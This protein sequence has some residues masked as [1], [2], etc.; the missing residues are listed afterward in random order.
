MENFDYLF[1]IVTISIFISLFLAVF[2]VT[3][4]S[5]NKLSNRL[6]ALFLVLTTIDVSGFL[7]QPA[8]GEMSNLAMFRNLVIFLQLPTLYLY[9]LSASYTNFILKW[10]HLL[11]VLSFVLVN[12]VFV[13]RFYLANTSEKISFLSDF[14]NVFEVQFNHVFLHVQVAF[15]IVLI[16]LALRKAKKLYLQNYTGN[17][18]QSHQWLFQL[19]V[20]ITIFYVLALVKNIFKFSTNDDVSDQI[21]IGLYVLN[22]VIICWYLFKALHHPTLFKSVN[23]NLKLV[24]TIISE[25]KKKSTATVDNITSNA[26]L[27]KLQAYMKTEKPFLNASLTIQD[28]S[29][30]IDIPVRELSVLI[31]HTLEQHFFDFVN[32]YRIKKAQELLIDTTDTKR[33]VLEILYEVGFNSKSSFNTAFKKHTGVTPTAYRKNNS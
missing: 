10:K 15:Y 14:K 23:S 12:L 33:T 16:F 22:L 31:N 11:H 25:E 27:Q 18:L 8:A 13:P 21:T 2:L 29:D 4:S 20:A 24:E 7:Y 3:V 19:S 26:E 30:A 9:I 5:K 1:T 6:F 28:V 17:S 32:S